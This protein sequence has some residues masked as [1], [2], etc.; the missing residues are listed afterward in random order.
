MSNDITLAR[1]YAR[2]AFDI[3]N[4][5]G[6]L[7]AWSS[8]LF[9]SSAIAAD[10]SVQDALQHPGLSAAQAVALVEPQ[11]DASQAYKTFLNALAEARRLNVLTHIQQQF[12]DLRAEAEKRRQVTIT[13][14]A[15]IDAEAMEKIKAALA[16]RFGTSIEI[17]E[18]IDP[19]LIGGAIIDA[20]DAV[21]DGSVQAR[22]HSL[23]QAIIR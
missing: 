18:V 5:T 16:K 1:P 23:Q 11:S 13:A 22:L 10:A 12:E 20:G 9:A 2:A 7:D 3:A 19:S 21:F 14:A 17:T 8:A 4:E 15:Q 6:S